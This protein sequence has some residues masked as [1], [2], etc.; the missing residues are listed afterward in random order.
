MPFYD[1]HIHTSFSF[2]AEEN[3]ELT[4]K[5]A[6]EMGADGLCFTEHT[7]AGHSYEQYADW[8]G[9]FDVKKYFETIDSLNEKYNISIKKGVE[10]GLTPDCIESTLKFVAENDFDFVIASQHIID[11]VDPYDCKEFYDGDIIEIINHY[12]E[13]IYL[14]AKAFAD[15]DVVAHIGYAARCAP[16]PLELKYSNHSDML[17]TLF[18]YLI[19]NGK[20]IEINTSG[21]KY[22][23]SP[24]PVL[25]IVRRYIEMGGEIITMGSDAHSADSVCYRFSDAIE[26]LKEAGAKYICSFDK[27]KPIFHSII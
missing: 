2:D 7:E 26:F 4:V 17:D 19:Q 8:D 27:R 14:N 6:E 1:S 21:Y 12:I 3:M 15:F 16:F 23:A 24:I 10:A 11:G 5:T 25:S 9:F 20:G 13:E 22:S 18:S